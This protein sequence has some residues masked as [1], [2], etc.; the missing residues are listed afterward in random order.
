MDTLHEED[1][2]TALTTH[3]YLALNVW[4]TKVDKINHDNKS[5]IL[6]IAIADKN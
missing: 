6:T 5:L 1:S 2:T 3:S 4:N